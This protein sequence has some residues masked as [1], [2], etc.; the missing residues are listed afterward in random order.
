MYGTQW[1]IYFFE[2]LQGADAKNY[3][4]HLSE[5]AAVAVIRLTVPSPLRFAILK[6][7]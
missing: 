2:T 6:V 1:L 5:H 7:A 4:R 3:L